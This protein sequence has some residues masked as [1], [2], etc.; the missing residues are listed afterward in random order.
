MIL[1]TYSISKVI[2]GILLT[3]ITLL[4]LVIAYKK[5]LARLG[6]GNPIKE[7]Y[8]VLYGLEESPSSKE[9]SFYFTSNSE[10]HIELSLLTNELT[11]LQIIAEKTVKEG[12][13]IT[14]FDTTTI[15]NGTYYF[16]LKTDNQKTMKK[17]IV[18]NN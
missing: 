12:G 4:I 8:C 5:L 18:A 9:V 3:S 11:T 10:R 17:M 2:I 13:H 1:M 16:C 15:P 6:K 14:R 7:D